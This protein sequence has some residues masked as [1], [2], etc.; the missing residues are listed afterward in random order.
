MGDLP[1]RLSEF[2]GDLLKDLRDR[3]LLPVV[4]LLV[5]AIIAVPLLIGGGTE[6]PEGVPIASAPPDGAEELDAVV[7]SGDSGVRNF[8]NRIE[9]RARNPFKQQ[10]PGMK[11]S[12][13]SAEDDEATADAGA[14]ADLGLPA[15][16]GL[17]A[18]GEGSTIPSTPPADSTSPETPDAQKP[19]RVTRLIRMTI[20][21]RISH[22]GKKRDIRAVE[23]LTLL[24]GSKSPVTQYVGAT[25]DAKRA[26]F[27]VSPAVVSTEGDGNCDPGRNN[28]QFLILEPGESQYFNY[29]EKAKRYKLKLLAINRE[30]IKEEKGGR[31]KGGGGGASAAEVG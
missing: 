27:V 18:G 24:P 8:Q 10:Y 14:D 13:G 1:T 5:V 4:G 11:S 6:E 9:G 21:V 30:V 29:G 23:P 16:S 12:D 25:Q 2:G 28:C 17:G 26:S 7:L 19:R 31:G 20:D 15:D 22:S 3:R